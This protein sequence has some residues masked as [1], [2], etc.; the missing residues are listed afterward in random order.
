MSVGKA[1]G[2]VLYD[3]HGKTSEAF[4]MKIIG[5]AIYFLKIKSRPP[6]PAFE[7]FFILFNSLNAVKR[8]LWFLCSVYENMNPSV[9]GCFPQSLDFRSSEDTTG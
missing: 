9:G 5:T 6:R 3:F 7:Q 8:P 1:G 4:A 2:R